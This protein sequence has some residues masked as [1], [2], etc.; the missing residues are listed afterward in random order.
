MSPVVGNENSKAQLYS[1]Y[2]LISRLRDSGLEQTQIFSIITQ[3][4]E[5]EPFTIR[6][7]D[8]KAVA[9]YMDKKYEGYLGG[10]E[11]DMGAGN[12]HAEEAE[13]KGARRKRK[14]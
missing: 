5:D 8:P 2:R 6:F 11:F 12:G 10:S 1:L 14:G 13:E 7:S 9:K 3:A 4:Y